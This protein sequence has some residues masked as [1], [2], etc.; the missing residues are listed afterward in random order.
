MN[1]GRPFTSFD[2]WINAMIDEEIA[3][4]LK[5]KD[6]KPDPRDMWDI[7]AYDSF[8]SFDDCQG[9]TP[10]VTLAISV[11]MLASLI[12]LYL[13]P[14]QMTITNWGFI[15]DDP[16]RKY[17]LTILSSFFLER[18]PVVTVLNVIPLFIYGQ[19][20][21]SYLG[22]IKYVLLIAVSIVSAQISFMLFYSDQ[23]NGIFYGAAGGTLGIITF[24]F[25]RFFSIG[26]L[27]DGCMA[28]ECTTLKKVLKSNA[29]AFLPFCFLVFAG[30]AEYTKGRG[31][32]ELHLW[33]L[34]HIAGIAG[35]V[36]FWL[37]SEGLSKNRHYLR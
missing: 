23:H 20:V 14:R 15:P 11:A 29:M 5:R 12:V 32:V 31:H 17:G 36:V 28:I 22:V 34:N 10:F 7:S 9:Q 4:K 27:K 21:E 13:I 37:I 8:L 6:R 35:G 2:L 25:L 1:Y 16:F 24:Y 3:E 33:Y 18:N 30:V 19:K 26:K